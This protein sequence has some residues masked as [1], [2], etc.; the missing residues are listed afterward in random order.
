MEKS[1]GAV[2]FRKQEGRTMFLLL[3]Y[4]SASHRTDKEY[5]DLPKGHIEPGETEGKTVLREVQEETGLTE[6]K[7]I[8]KFR[9]VIKYFFKWEGKTI[10]KT[11]AFYLLE[12]ETE[13]IKISPEHIGFVW[14]P[15]EEAKERLSFKNAKEILEK[16][17]NFFNKNA[18][19]S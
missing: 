12:T 5:W 9:E 8:P 3:H 1:A 14:L 17:N 18:A 19:I 2:I 15:Y 10:F 4:P 16:A 7:F 11:V 13:E 6:F